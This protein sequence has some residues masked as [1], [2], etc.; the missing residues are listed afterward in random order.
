[1]QAGV[2]MNPKK[3]LEPMRGLKEIF[4]IPTIIYLPAF[5]LSIAITIM[6][7]FVQPFSAGYAIGGIFAAT[8][9]FI[10][11]LVSIV[12]PAARAAILKRDGIHGTA[13]VIKKEQRTRW[14]STLEPSNRIQVPTSVITFEFTPEGSTSPLQLEAEAQKVTA[15]MQAGKTMKITYARTNP[16]IVKLPG[17]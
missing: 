10:L 16:R 6:S 7:F 15:S 9:F 5:L 1:M 3:R 8:L 17:E 13:I 11:I 2:L 14:L 12:I 4:Q